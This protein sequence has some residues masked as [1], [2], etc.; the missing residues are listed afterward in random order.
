M[1]YATYAAPGSRA[2]RVATT[3]ELV[4]ALIIEPAVESP[5]AWGTTQA[6]PRGADELQGRGNALAADV[7]E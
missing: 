6:S 2:H 5:R 4:I 1:T 3:G 7:A